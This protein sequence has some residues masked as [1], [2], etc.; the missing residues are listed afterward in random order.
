MP[1]LN[2]HSLRENVLFPPPTR[3]MYSCL[4]NA[5][6]FVCFMTGTF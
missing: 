6:I 5:G 3:Q 4:H 2:G 1:V